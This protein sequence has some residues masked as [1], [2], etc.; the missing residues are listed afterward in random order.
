MPTQIP[1]S[2]SDARKRNAEMAAAADLPPV[3]P[4]MSDWVK[5]APG[6]MI[7][8]GTPYVVFRSFETTFSPGNL[9]EFTVLD[10]ADH[11]LW[12]PPPPAPEPIWS[13]I[14]TDGE[15]PTLAKVTWS[16]RDARPMTA[17][18]YVDGEILR[19]EWTQGLS[20]VNFIE[21]VE[22]LHTYNPVT[23]VPVERALIDEAARLVAWWDDD[24][25]DSS[26]PPSS[27]RGVG[28]IVTALAA[29]ADGA[30]S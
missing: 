23:H 4:D 9:F 27:D 30:E 19:D 21:S 25:L 10:L 6:D 2:T 8:A 28:Q 29:L 13:V 11:A 26:P 16:G 20:H 15:R 3:L 22:L 5:R 14:S 18:F 24:S 12:T 7:E 1:A 17:N